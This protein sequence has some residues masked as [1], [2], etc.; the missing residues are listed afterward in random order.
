MAIAIVSSKGQFVIPAEIRKE[1]GIEPQTKLRIT[2]SEDKT[3]L[4]LEPMPKDPIKD[5]RGIMKKA[6]RSV[7]R[8]SRGQMPIPK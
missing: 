1:L 6:L 3:K 2:L 4:T 7:S 5:L 8:E